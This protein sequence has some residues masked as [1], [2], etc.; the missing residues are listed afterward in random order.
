MSPNCEIPLEAQTSDA[1]FT[2]GLAKGG[3][4]GDARELF[5]SLLYSAPSH[6]FDPYASSSQVDPY[7]VSVRQS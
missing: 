5:D 4:S 6:F 2:K 1:L 7:M 3:V